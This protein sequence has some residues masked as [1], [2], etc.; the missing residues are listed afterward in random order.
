MFVSSVP[1]PTELGERVLESVVGHQGRRCLRIGV[2]EA[3]RSDDLLDLV[4]QI[5]VGL[6]GRFGFDEQARAVHIDDP[7]PHRVAHIRHVPHRTPR[8]GRL[9]G[10]EESRVATDV[11]ANGE[12]HEL[13]GVPAHADA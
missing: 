9:P 2:V 5:G 13:R 11:V 8:K 10:V 7:H 12:H 4:P 3:D 1:I 6:R